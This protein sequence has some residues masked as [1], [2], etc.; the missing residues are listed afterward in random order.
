MVDRSDVEDY[1]GRGNSGFERSRS[2][3]ELGRVRDTFEDNSGN[4]GGARL[5]GARG[6]TGTRGRP[7]AEEDSAA[8][9]WDRAT[10]AYT[11]T[12]F[13]ARCLSRL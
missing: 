5:K 1:S 2:G 9:I 6:S 12:R 8:C 10:A 11:D 13:H 3:L 4:K 7:T